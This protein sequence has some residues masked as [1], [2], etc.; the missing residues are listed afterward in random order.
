MQLNNYKVNEGKHP[1]IVIIGKTSFPV[2]SASSNRILTICKGFINAGATVS[3]YSFGLS[4]L[5]LSV[6]GKNSSGS[7]SGIKWMFFNKRVTAFKCK[8]LN[9]VY[10]LL[11]QIKGYPLLLFRYLNK[12][13]LFFT[14][15]T[16]LGYI[17]PLWI[18]SRICCGRIILFRSEFPAHKIRKK[19]FTRIV[20]S[21]IYPI[22]IS[23]FDAMLLM[24]DKLRKYFKKWAGKNAVIE[25]IPLSVDLN[26]FNTTTESPFSFPYIAYCGSITNAKDGLDILIRCFFSIHEKFPDIRL[27]IIGGGSDLNSLKSFASSI[28]QEKEKVIFTDIVDHSKIPQYLLNARILALARPKSIQAEGGFPSKL[29][30]YLATGKP[31]I[32][33]DTGE[34]SKYLVDKV[35][36][37]IAEPDNESDFTKKLKWLL[38]NP[39]EAEKIGINGRETAMNNFDMNKIGVNILKTLNELN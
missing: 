31:V 22:T 23:R 38:E 5:P 8:I 3:V 13:P 35:N 39:E 1:E 11:G 19:Y 21:Y 17:I 34:I 24:T 7:I 6:E 15:Q 27:V 32:V 4:R 25:I 16:G 26:M 18:L 29:G 2:S 20:E 33:T 36:A 10:L 12:K 37:R 14:S 30:E 9:G 28:F